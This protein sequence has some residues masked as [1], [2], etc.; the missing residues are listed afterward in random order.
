[1]APVLKNSSLQLK[2]TKTRN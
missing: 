2:K 1:M